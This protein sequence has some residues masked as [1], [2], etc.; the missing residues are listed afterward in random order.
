M[1]L[2]A[3]RWWSPIFF[4]SSVLLACLAAGLVL[5]I[6]AWRR[7]RRPGQSRTAIAMLLLGTTGLYLASTPLVATAIARRMESAFPP[8]AAESITRADAIV[9]LGGAMHAAVGP[10]GTV[11]EFAHHA[12]DRFE[13]GV[14]ALLAGRAPLIAFGG[15]LTGVE[16]ATTEAEWNRGRALAR[17]VRPESVIVGDPARYTSDEAEGLA[18]EL[19]ERGA[20][21]LIVVSSALHV[22][23]AVATYRALGFEVHALPC[24]FSTRGEA[25]RFSPAL[26]I[27]RGMALA[28]VD[29]CAKEYLGRLVAGTR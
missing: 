13:T 14:R 7:G 11:H 19:R 16:G 3:T 1:N 15:G 21:S 8:V 9:V 29:S 4:P 18:A 20:R 12:S 17:G 10:D 26:L 24:D 5:S 25:E 23:R 28:L 6:V 27:P 2:V 22:P